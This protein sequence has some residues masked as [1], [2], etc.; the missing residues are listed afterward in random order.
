MI[1]VLRLGDAIG[2]SQQHLSGRELT[3]FDRVLKIVDRA[4]RRSAR[5]CEGRRLA[6]RA[7]H[8]RRVVP[9]VHVNEQT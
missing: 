8:N 9:G 5:K 1:L 2:V 3:L 7:Y 6:S 4:E